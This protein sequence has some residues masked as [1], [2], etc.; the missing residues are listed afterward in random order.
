L[1]LQAMC[2][3]LQGTDMGTA[4]RQSSYAYPIIL[5]SHL[6]GIALFGGM[7]VMSDLRLLR[8]ALTD[9][10]LA[11]VTGRLRLWKRLGLVWMI[12]FG[13]L[14]FSAKAA[15]YYMNPYFRTKVILLLLTGVHAF[16]FRGSVYNRLAEID[17]ADAIP[18]KAKAAA[19]LSFGLWA[20]ILV[21]GRLIGYYEL[22]N[23]P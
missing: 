5:S 14:L 11:E 3:W 10:S 6:T 21:F 2:E 16:V 20:G 17:K 15:Q 12:T 8:F 23:E 7:L 4:I 1:S 9:L 19:W 13:F 18:A 22:P